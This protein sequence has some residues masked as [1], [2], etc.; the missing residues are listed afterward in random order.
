VG[1]LIDALPVVPFDLDVVRI[2]AALGA[3]LR[4]P[5]A[6]VGAHDLMIA[7]TAIS[8]DYTVATRD[9]RSLPRIKGLAVVRW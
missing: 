6:A 2:H 9:L 1:R 4:A 8:L 7:A 5:G 3:D